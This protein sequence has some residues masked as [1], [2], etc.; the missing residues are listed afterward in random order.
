MKYKI[1]QKRAECIG[2]GACAAVC[3][4]WEMS[5]DNKAR[6]KKTTITEEE[7]KSNKEAVDICPVKCI[8]IKKTGK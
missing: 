2:C 8:K 3:D 4:N 6:A 5:S 7:L 1:I